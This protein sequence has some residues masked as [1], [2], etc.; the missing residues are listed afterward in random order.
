MTFKDIF[1]GLSRTLSFNFRDF[2]GQKWF[3]R[4]FQVLEFSIKKSWT[5]QKVWEPCAWSQITSEQLAQSYY[6]TAIRTVTIGRKTR[7]NTK[8]L[9][10]QT[11]DWSCLATS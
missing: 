2:P 7:I 10:W 6:F 5:F 4:T 9:M 8:T 11:Q 1:P 3:S